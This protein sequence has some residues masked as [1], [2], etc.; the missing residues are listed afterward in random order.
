MEITTNLKFG[1]RLR[2]RRHRDFQRLLT[3]GRRARDQRLEIWVL[4]NGL[5]HSRFGLIV[6]R[7]H[8]GAVR[9]NQIK[10]L[11]RESF[12]LIRPELPGAL[13][14]ACAPRVGAEIAL[15]GVME[16]LARL[17]SRLAQQ[18]ASD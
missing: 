5:G 16:S 17:T 11:L 10:R 13:D 14:I 12:R 4:P 15:E 1:R 9:R 7:K 2:L 3:R 18:I 8:G 6:G